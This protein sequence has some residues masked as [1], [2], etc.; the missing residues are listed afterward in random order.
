MTIYFVKYKKIN[1]E[2]YRH[3]DIFQAVN[4]FV[5]NL[6]FTQQIKCFFLYFTVVS[7]IHEDSTVHY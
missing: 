6:T 1:S 7:D 4:I 5:W 2:F 3:Y